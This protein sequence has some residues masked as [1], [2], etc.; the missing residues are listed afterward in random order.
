MSDKDIKKQTDNLKIKQMRQF[1]SHSIQGLF[2]MF[3]VKTAMKIWKDCDPHY[4]PVWDSI[5]WSIIIFIA[6]IILAIFLNKKDSDATQG[7]KG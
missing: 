5:F 7:E 1:R 3:V 6:I 4:D 2:I